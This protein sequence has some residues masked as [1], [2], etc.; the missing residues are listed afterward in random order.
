MIEGIILGICGDLLDLLG[1][2]IDLDGYEGIVTDLHDIQVDYSFFDWC[3]VLVL[4]GECEELEYLEGILVENGYLGSKSVIWEVLGYRYLEDIGS[5]I[6]RL[7][8]Y[9]GIYGV[10]FMELMDRVLM[11]LSNGSGYSF[12]RDLWWNRIL[13][14]NRSQVD[15]GINFGSRVGRWDRLLVRDYWDE[16][17]C[18]WEVL[19]FE[20]SI[21]VRELLRELYEQILEQAKRRVEE[22]SFRDLMDGIEKLGRHMA[23]MS[24]RPTEIYSIES[25]SREEKIRLIRE[26]MDSVVGGRRVSG[27]LGSCVGDVLE[28]NGGSESVEGMEGSDK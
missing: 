18:S 21:W 25:V 9:S 22:A 3:L 19:D 5:H 14:S 11:V 1:I 23:L 8:R 15:I 13:G 26:Y 20:M 27:S 4:L 6:G 2:G 12:G 10:I 7:L 17:I 24:G 16:G 28:D